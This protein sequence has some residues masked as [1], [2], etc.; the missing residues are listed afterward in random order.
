MPYDSDSFLKVIY[1]DA[2]WPPKKGKCIWGITWDSLDERWLPYAVKHTVRDIEG[3]TE[4]PFPNPHKL[5]KNLKVT[6][7]GIN[8]S[9]YLIAGG[10]PFFVFE[11]A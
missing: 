7:G 5:C 4:Y 8:R 10:H 1:Y 9:V 2:A 3:I 6:V 11:R